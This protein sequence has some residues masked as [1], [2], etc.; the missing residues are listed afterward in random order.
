M[1]IYWKFIIP[2]FSIL[3]WT[4]PLFSIQ[5]LSR[6]CW[7]VTHLGY[8]LDVPMRLKC[9]DWCN[10]KWTGLKSIIFDSFLVHFEIF[11]HFQMKSICCIEHFFTASDL[12][13]CAHAGFNLVLQRK[14]QSVLCTLHS[15]SIYT[16]LELLHRREDVSQFFACLVN[17]LLLLLLLFCCI[18]ACSLLFFVYLM[19][20]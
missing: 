2:E 13:F 4:P 5:K 9:K 16:F 8:N 7:V 1:E 11:L 18:I 14:V 17:L 10:K 3:M 6:P 20:F 12:I 19:Q 15:L